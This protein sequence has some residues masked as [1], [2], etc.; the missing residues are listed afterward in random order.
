MMFQCRGHAAATYMAL[1][2]NH[3]HL[4]RQNSNQYQDFRVALECVA[5]SSTITITITTGIADSGGQDT[6][7]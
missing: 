6:G 4:P 7:T 1:G 3:S 2:K 5:S